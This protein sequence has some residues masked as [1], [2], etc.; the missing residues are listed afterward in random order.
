MSYLIFH[1]GAF[2]FQLRVPAAL[3]PQFG[4][5]IRVNLQ[6]R[7]ATAARPIALRLAADWLARFDLARFGASD[8][9][10]SSGSVAPPELPSAAAVP[11]AAPWGLECPATE[12]HT[13]PKVPNP[14]STPVGASDGPVAHGST[15]DD[16]LLQLWR[17]LD[18]DRASSTVKDMQAALRSF[19]S[20]CSTPVSLLTRKDVADFR[21]Q[22]LQA[23][24]ARGTVAKRIGMIS[25]LLQVG[26][27]GGLLP[28][29]VARGLKIP[30]ATVPT[31]VR[32][33]FTPE[34]L[35]RLFA[36]PV[37]RTGKRPVG[38]GGEACVWLPMLALVTGA[39]LEELAQLR[40]DDILID[41]EFGPLL[42]ITDTGE[43]QELKTD[44]SRRIIPLHPDF[45][46]AGFLAYVEAVH[47][48]RQAWL[49]PA[50]EADHDGRRGANF[51]KWFMRQIR[52]PRGLGIAD[53]RLV[54]HSFRHGFKTLCRAAGIAEEVHDALT[55]H[56][57][58]A[59]S[60]T[61]G[62]MPIAPLVAAIHSLRLPVRLPTIVGGVRHD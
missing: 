34:E 59:V 44:G 41:A 53:P 2:W 12:A 21:D 47:D 39:R 7:E 16:A 50:L 24:L 35:Q 4:P 36:L 62:D 1:H 30:R 46:R 58:G 32:R 54:F 27:D 18:P 42:R 3:R 45:L 40:T 14:P 31:V 51:G 49:F 43:D 23:R 28:Y 52:S 6:T 29:N 26:F 55:G 56:V 60:R 37:F 13:A 19:R 15:T 20:S 38:A 17:R 25:T 10:A 57:T 33:G 48:E 8:L 9:P 5:V 11:S 22:L 61:Y